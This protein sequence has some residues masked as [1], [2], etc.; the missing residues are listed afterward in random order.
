MEKGVP[1]L[2]FWCR[3]CGAVVEVV[4]CHH[5]LRTYGLYSHSTLSEG[6]MKDYPGIGLSHHEPMEL[7]DRDSLCLGL[8]S[9][10]YGLFFIR[11]EMGG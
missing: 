2:P 9:H 8:A 5:H 3:H 7:L 1:P 6:R 10:C 4:C 11:L